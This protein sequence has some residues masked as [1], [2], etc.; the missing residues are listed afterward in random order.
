VDPARSLIK[1]ALDQLKAAVYDMRPAMLDD[2]GLT[3]ALRW[4]A[5]ARADQPGLAVITNLDEAGA[6]RL[7]PQIEIALYRV[8]QEAL[9]NVVKHASASRVDLGLEIKPG[10]AA[11][12]IFDNG[13]GFD[14]AEARGRGLGLLSMRE[15][16]SQLGGRFNI[17]TEPGGGTRVYAVVTL[18]EDWSREETRGP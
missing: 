14:L 11:L 10:F 9:A 15:R 3:A 17:V 16:I 7:P 4:Y 8:G 18:P 5:K 12:T 13:R 1:Q 6:R 2:L